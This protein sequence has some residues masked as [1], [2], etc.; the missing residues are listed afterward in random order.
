MK[1]NDILVS[2]VSSSE[3]VKNP[4]FMSLVLGANMLAVVAFGLSEQT[5][6][7]FLKTLTVDD[8]IARAGAGGVFGL[9]FTSK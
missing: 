1:Y 5:C 4:L 3:N 9:F 2:P 6:C 7:F 8:A